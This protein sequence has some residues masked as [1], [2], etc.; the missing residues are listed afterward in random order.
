MRYLRSR[1]LYWHEEGQM[2]SVGS[3]PLRPISSLA[4][5]LCFDRIS[6]SCRSQWGRTVAP[7]AEGSNPMELDDLDLVIAELQRVRDALAAPASPAEM[8][9]SDVLRFRART[10]KALAAEI[11]YLSS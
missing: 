10:A 6:L 5:S 2:D 8:A 9:F 7:A 4:R 1:T 3:V 11:E